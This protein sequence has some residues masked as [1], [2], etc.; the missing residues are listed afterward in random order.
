MPAANGWAERKRRDFQVPRRQEKAG[1]EDTWERNLK[2]SWAAGPL[3]FTEGNRATKLR[4]ELEVL[5]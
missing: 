2:A 1:R 4:A 3:G 5:S